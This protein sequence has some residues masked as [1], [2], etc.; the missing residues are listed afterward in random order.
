MLVGKEETNVKSR[1]S[2]HILVY[3]WLVATNENDAY[4]LRCSSIFHK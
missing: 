4:L 3:T 1:K 2:F